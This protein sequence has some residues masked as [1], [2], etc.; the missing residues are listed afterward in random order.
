MVRHRRVTA[1]QRGFMSNITTPHV[2][3]GIADLLPL[4]LAG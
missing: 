2:L 3:D 4:V 1:K